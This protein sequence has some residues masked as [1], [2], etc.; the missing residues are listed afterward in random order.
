VGVGTV[1]GAGILEA[2]LKV[3]CSGIA[4]SEVTPLAVDSVYDARPIQG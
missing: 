3:A 1:A 4:V 2:R